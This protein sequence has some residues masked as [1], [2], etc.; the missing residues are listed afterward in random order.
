M[1]SMKIIKAE[2]VTVRLTVFQVEE[3]NRLISTGIVKTKAAAIQHIVNQHIILGG[4]KN[5]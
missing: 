5:K 2:Q 1:N 4:D 3:L